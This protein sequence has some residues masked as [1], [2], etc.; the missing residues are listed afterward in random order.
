MQT[1]LIHQAAR[2]Q[3][4]VPVSAPGTTTARARICPYEGCH[5]IIPHKG[6]IARHMRTHT[7]EKPFACPYSDCDRRFTQKSDVKKHMRTHTGEK[8]FACSY[9]GCEK[10]FASSS[11]MV[12]HW[13]RHIAREDPDYSPPRPFLCWHEGCNKRFQHRH[14]L[15]LHLCAHSGNKIFAC[16]HEECGKRFSDRSNLKRHLL[17]HSGERPCLCP[18][19]CGKSFTRKAHLLSHIQKNHWSTVGTWLDLRA[20]E[21]PEPGTPVARRSPG[22]SSSDAASP[23]LTTAVD[24]EVFADTDR[25]FDESLVDESLFDENLIG[26]W[27]DSPP[28]QTPATPPDKGQDPFSD[29][30]IFWQWFM[31]PRD[32]QADKGVPAPV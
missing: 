18:L 8:P 14:H 30:D 2:P 23:G 19:G 32:S 21:R 15:K 7:G 22:S 16:S 29:P 13:R 17:S 10:W 31:T 5:R 4:P 11:A 12:R 24:T 28:G 20:Q 26:S 6:G 27:A 25:L 1:V 3:Q 9:E